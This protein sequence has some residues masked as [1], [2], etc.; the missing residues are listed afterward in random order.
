MLQPSY[1]CRNIFAILRGR[2]SAQEVEL[3]ATLFRYID[4]S[5]S[6]FFVPFLF[7]TSSARK[8]KRNR[9]PRQSFLQLWDI[10]DLHFSRFCTSAISRIHCQLLYL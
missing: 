5:N 2:D 10:E 6:T 9:K 1:V 8:Q 3:W 7:I 4:H